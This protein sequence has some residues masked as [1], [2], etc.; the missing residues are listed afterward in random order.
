MV[1]QAL[2]RLLLDASGLPVPEPPA[3]EVRRAAREIIRRPEF[4]PP[5]RTVSQVV[6]DWI[7]RQFERL[8]QGVGGG[9]RVGIAV[10]VLAVALIVFLLVRFA[11]SVQSDPG[12]GVVVEHDTGRLPT[13]WEADA[14]A[15]EGAG[16]WR[17]AVRC[18]YRALVAHLAAAGVVREIPGRTAGEYRAEVAAQLPAASSGFAAA[19]ELFERAWYSNHPTGP[20]DAA[21]MRNLS[22]EVTSVARKVPVGVS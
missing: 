4:R 1:T 19:S 7:S 17:D 12:K 10:A 22:E 21:Q 5:P 2:G 14:A 15:H 16:R 6:Y 13:D 18:R 8:Q 9:T 20:E 3:D 11:R